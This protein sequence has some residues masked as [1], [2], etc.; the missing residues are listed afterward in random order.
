MPVIGV[1]VVLGI[2]VL[3]WWFVGAVICW[4]TEDWRHRR[5]RH[6]MAVT[7]AKAVECATVVD[8]IRRDTITNLNQAATA[9]DSWLSGRS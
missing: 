7:R 1:V 4:E 3:V 8:Q 5:P 6:Q 2:N 9:T